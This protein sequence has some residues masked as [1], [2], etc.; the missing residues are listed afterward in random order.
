MYLLFKNVSQRDQGIVE[1]IGKWSNFTVGY[2]PDTH[3][4]IFDYRVLNSRIISEKTAR[5]YMFIDAYKDYISV[6]TNTPQ[7]DTLQVLTSEEEDGTKVKYTLTEEDKESAISIMKEM[8]RLILDEVYDKRALELNLGVSDLEFGSWEQQRSEAVA[9][10]AD[11]SA[12]TPLLSSLSSARDITLSEMVEKVINAVEQY[13]ARQTD[14][15]SAKQAIE[16]EIKACSSIAD[17]HRLLHNRYEI[18]MSAAQMSDENVTS[19]ATFNL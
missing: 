8:M 11:N 13:N 6:R 19:S 2:L 15:L 18:S 12:P 14:L 1:T 16:A 4:D 5:G 9:W 10:T 17:C 3:K 7:N